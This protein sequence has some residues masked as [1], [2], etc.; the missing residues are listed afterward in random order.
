MSY[1]DQ[2]LLPGERVQQRAHLHKIIYVLPALGTAALLAFGVAAATRGTWAAGVLLALAALPLAW[3]HVI[4]TSS[5]FAVTDKR[6]IIK[7]GV[8]RRRTLE[9][10][11]GKVE[12]IGVDQT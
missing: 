11:L 10:M 8:M 5:E 12:G 3:V 6:V 9:T 4:Y 2:H 1:V 7:V